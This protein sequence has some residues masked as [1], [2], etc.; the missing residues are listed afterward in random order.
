MLTSGEPVRDDRAAKPPLMPAMAMQV[1][2]DLYVS[3]IT[4]LVHQDTETTRRR[5]RP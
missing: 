1:R 5:S 3:A 4:P 2:R